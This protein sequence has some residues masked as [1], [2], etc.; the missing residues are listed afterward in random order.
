M[1]IAALILGII[2][3]IAGLF[4]AGLALTVGGIGSAMG[5]ANSSTVLVGGVIALVTS[6]VG[7]IG[8]AIALKAPRAAGWMMLAAA[9]VG[10]FAISAGYVVACPLLLVGGILAFVGSRASASVAS[11][12]L[13]GPTGV[14]IP[15]PPPPPP[16]PEASNQPL[17]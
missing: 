2:G 17:P 5:T 16:Q 3:G 6:I 13:S 8:G 10:V 1:R 4:G 7:I 9:L 15:P 14:H 12:A 11:P